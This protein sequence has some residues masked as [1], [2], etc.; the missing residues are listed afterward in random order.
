MELLVYYDNPNEA[1]DMYLK[2]LTKDC[3]QEGINIKLINDLTVLK[4]DLRDGFV[5]ALALMPC[6][7]AD[8]EAALKKLFTKHPREDVDNISGESFYKDATA[9]G[10]FD[11]IVSQDPDRVANISVIGRGKVGKSLIDQLITY[12]YTVFEFNSKSEHEFMFNAIKDYSWY[13]VGLASEQVFSKKECDHLIFTKLIDSGNNF[14]TTE[15]V[16][17]GKWTRKK[18]I[19]RIKNYYID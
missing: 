5:P 10:I 6:K 9:E 12:G 17:C 18:I 19:E 3:E 7:D 11:Y 13:A 8:T 14:D 16:R 15:K 4:E 2:W 1:S